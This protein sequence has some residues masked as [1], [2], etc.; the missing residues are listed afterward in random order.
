MASAM[1]TS[2]MLALAVICFAVIQPASAKPEGAADEK[3]GVPLKTI[4]IKS[5]QGGKF[6]VIPWTE[7]DCEEKTEVC[8][9]K[10]KTQHNE[11]S[12]G[13]CRGYPAARN[14]LFKTVDGVT[15]VSNVAY[16]SN[17]TGVSAAGSVVKIVDFMPR[18]T[19]GSAS[20]LAVC[21]SEGRAYAI[22]HKVSFLRAKTEDSQMPPTKFF[23]DQYEKVLAYVLDHWDDVCKEQPHHARKIHN[24]KKV[25]DDWCGV[26]S[27]ISDRAGGDKCFVKY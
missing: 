5:E 20:I 27:G 15:S 7:N 10:C 18:D 2:V 23:A 16:F 11:C 21:P 13:S 3:C 25:L 12:A 19:D 1:L 6:C 24:P 4:P 17:T 14:E 9:T 8:I 26:I 22:E